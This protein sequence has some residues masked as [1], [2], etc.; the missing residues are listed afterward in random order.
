MAQRAKGKT[1]HEV[2]VFWVSG[3]SL[4]YG[5]NLIDLRHRSHPFEEHLTLNFTATCIYPDRFKDRTATARLHG[6]RDFLARIQDPKADLPGG[7][8]SVVATK[9]RFEF[10]ADVPHDACWQLAAA[11]S[12]GSIRSMLANAPAF[13]PKHSFINSVSFH[14]P[15]FDPV[16]YVG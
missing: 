10:W 15:E 4:D 3:P 16:D 6:Y 1:A 5:M 2:F 9:T 12:A 14:G 7:V 13:T 11:M 8:A